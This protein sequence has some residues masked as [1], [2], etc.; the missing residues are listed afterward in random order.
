MPARLVARLGT[1]LA[2]GGLTE[3]L[4]PITDAAPCRRAFRALRRQLTA[5]GGRLKRRVKGFSPVYDVFWHEPIG[6]W[7]VV[8][9]HHEPHPNWCGFGL[10][11]P[12]DRTELSAFVAQ[13]NPPPSGLSSQFAGL[14]ATDGH[15][16]VF[17]AH[18]GKVKAHQRWFRRRSLLDA[19]RGRKVKVA[20]PNGREVDH[21][22]IGEVG[23]PRLLQQ[24]HRFVTEV[25]RF[26]A[27]HQQ[28][29]A[30]AHQ[31]GSFEKAFTPEFTGRKS[32]RHTGRVVSVC[33]HGDVVAE[34]ERLAGQHGL[35]TFNDRQRDLVAYRR[36]GTRGILFEV[37]TDTTTS[38]LYGVIGQLMLHGAAMRPLPHRV[39]V[40]PDTPTD[41]TRDTLAT[42][43]ITV[44]TYDW[45]GSVP[46]FEAAEDLLRRL[47]R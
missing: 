7:C 21:I 4:R 31:Q 46:V 10:E 47:G 45:D 20:F 29:P 39:L 27:Q 19:Y 17:L 16:G 38:S 35:K 1:R 3:T 41:Q 43:G 22:L 12:S 36:S 5:G 24:I 8:D 28:L 6:L 34:L 2:S 13:W 40:I 14:F 30:R 15:G 18:N 11:D 37:K 33:D 42:L 32:Y 9:G 25:V 26:K 44:L 23:A